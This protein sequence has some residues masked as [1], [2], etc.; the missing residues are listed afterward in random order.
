MDDSVSP[1]KLSRTKSQLAELNFPR[2]GI[3]LLNGDKMFGKVEKF[4]EFYIYVKNENG[5]VLD[6]PRRIIKRAF[7]LIEGGLKDG[8]ELSEQD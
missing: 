4:T 6:V 8:R 5:D 3:Q 7:L 1:R 2:I